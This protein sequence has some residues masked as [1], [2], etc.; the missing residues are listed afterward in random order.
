M[1]LPGTPAA[2]PALLNLQG[3]K[4]KRQRRQ[5]EIR[6]RSQK[7]SRRCLFKIGDAVRIKE[8]EKGGKYTV[9][10]S[11]LE[12]RDGGLGYR[13]KTWDSNGI[14]L[15]SIRHLKKSHRTPP[16][17]FKLVDHE[18]Q[19]ADLTA[20]V[21]R[22]DSDTKVTFSTCVSIAPL[23]TK[24]GKGSVSRKTEQPASRACSSL[25][26]LP[27]HLYE[28]TGRKKFRWRYLDVSDWKKY[29]VLPVTSSIPTVPLRSCLKTRTSDE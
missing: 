13:V 11:I 15:R 4:V 28:E 25:F 10:A 9:F 21:N 14:F 1:R 3:E 19:D 23:L 20:R 8:Q 5:E 26:S 29:S 18:A 24:R 6:G 17:D 22:A 7:R 2:F 16:H 27:A 12:V